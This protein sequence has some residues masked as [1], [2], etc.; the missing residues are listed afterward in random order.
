ME[1]R[2]NLLS[3]HHARIKD[4]R[5]A[6]LAYDELQTKYLDL[7]GRAHG[8]LDM[9][10]VAEEAQEQAKGDARKEEQKMNAARTIQIAW[11][12][13]FTLKKEQIQRNVLEKVVMVGGG[14]QHSRGPSWLKPKL[15][16]Q[17]RSS[18]MGTKFGLG[19]P[20]LSWPEL[21]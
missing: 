19:L 1:K 10:R 5:D 14:S 4:D 17:K 7:S 16:L 8:A 15:R 12:S 21:T 6:A 13:Y 2:W 9:L 20:G 11:Q 18:F 3:K